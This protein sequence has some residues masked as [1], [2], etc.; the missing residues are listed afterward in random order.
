MTILLVDDDPGVIQSLLAIVAALPGHEV[1]TATNGEEA[2]KLAD[3]VGLLITD[4]VMDP[5]DGFA[6][7]D[8]MAAR[9]P[10]LR[11]ILLTGYDLSD[12]PEQTRNHRLLQKPIDPADL[13]AAIKKEMPAMQAVKVAQPAG[14]KPVAVPARAAQLPQKQIPRVVPA[15]RPPVPAAPRVVTARGVHAV[16][17]V[18][19]AASI[20]AAKTAAAPEAGSE[21]IGQTIGAYRIQR[22]L[23]QGRWG[24]VYAAV[25]TAIN[26]PVSLRL[27]DAARASDTPT[28]ERFIGDARAKA[29]VQ[30]PSILSVFEAGE[31]GSHIFYAQEYVD[32]RNLAELGASGEKLDQ[33]AALK[34]LRAAAEG[35]GYYA[36]Q[37]TPHAPLDAAGIYL[38]AEGAPRL[39]NRAT[40]LAD[41]QPPYEQ[42]VAALGRT[43]LA[44]LPAGSA[45]SPP[46]RVLLG[47]MMQTTP[48]RAGGIPSWSALL[49]A[50]KELEPQVVPVEAAMITAQDR[51]AIAAVEAARKAQ[52]RSFFVNIAGL[53]S[54]LLL[55]GGA[56]Y[57]FVFRGRER[58]HDVMVHI[59]AGEFLFQ[60]GESVTLPEYW[61]DKYEVTIGQYAKFL[62]SLE[63]HPTVEFEDPREP[64]IKRGQGG[65]APKTWK[66]Y[67]ERAVRN[68]EV[69]STPT[70]LNSPVVEV[71][72]WDASAYAKWKGHELP[73]EKEWEKAARGLKGFAYPWG[74]EFDPRKLNSGSDYHSGN[75]AV[76][77]EFDGYIRYG[78]VDRQLKDRSPFEVIGMAGNVS[79]WIGDWTQVADRKAK[80]PIIKGGNFMSTDVKLDRRVTDIQASAQEFFLGFRTVRHTPPPK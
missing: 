31:A 27:L 74:D 11:T 66:I 16:A 73:T 51:A 19:K 60:S 34:V 62:K 55:A 42:E 20:P 71:D 13:V 6:L 57:W 26:R 18:P 15:G 39:A 37:K 49:L 46:V 21:L 54:A 5:M 75:P 50:L 12:Y 30:H 38:S 35:L 72:W 36:T 32:G 77:A 8:A 80:F 23:G 52:K 47:R 58:D 59:P 44:V 68:M 24:A 78:D 61:I 69:A 4:V 9:L 70:T 45:I 14:L 3:G 2:L 33:T 22:L 25:Q 28:R 43:L 10:D 56:I 53:V 1:R 17:A 40:Q 67:Y 7:R 76:R 65:H 48:G 79:E 29:R 41:E 63:A 64:P